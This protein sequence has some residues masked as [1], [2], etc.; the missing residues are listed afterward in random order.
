[1]PEFDAGGGHRFPEPPLRILAI[2]GGGALGTLARY[3]VVR[4]L[5]TAT[6]RFPWPTLSVNVAGSFLVGVIVTLVV[7][8]WPPTRFVRPFAAIGFCGGFTT[9]ST[10]AVE[11]VQRGQHGLV[12]LAAAY[13]VVSLV[14]GLVAAGLGI[15]L[16]R[17]RILAVGGDRSIPDPDDL[18]V[19]F[20]APAGHPD[21]TG[22]ARTDDAD[23]HDGEGRPS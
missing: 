6:L 8:R 10:M 18:G 21:A 13:L 15:T 7:E 2:A 19:L 3:G 4:N 1:V 9:F 11:A 5:P 12:G 14:S 16:V 23:D 20:A 17:G 22:A